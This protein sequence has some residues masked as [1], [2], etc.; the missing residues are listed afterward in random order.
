MW[1]IAE[2]ETNKI[3]LVTPSDTT[4]SRSLAIFDDK[5]LA[6]CYLKDVYIYRDK[7][8]IIKVLLKVK[9]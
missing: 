5:G 1:A 7:Y 3:V 9:K 4:I 2:K 6:E 8:R